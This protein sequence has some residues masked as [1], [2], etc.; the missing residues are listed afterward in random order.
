[1]NFSGKYRCVVVMVWGT[2][3]LELGYVYAQVDRKAFLTSISLTLIFWRICEQVCLCVCVCVY[4]HVCVCVR[5][6]ASMYAD[7]TYMRVMDAIYFPAV[8]RISLA[9]HLELFFL[10]IFSHSVVWHLTS[11]HLPAGGSRRPS[12]VILINITCQVFSTLSCLQ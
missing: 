6:C 4:V 10:H 7:A 11:F 5:V 2:A 12:A 8:I 3:C 1:M 9:L